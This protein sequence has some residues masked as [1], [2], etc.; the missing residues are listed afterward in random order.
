MTTEE[1]NKGYF[2][3]IR[4]R[5]RIERVDEDFYPEF[6]PYQ[7][8][9]KWEEDIVNFVER[10]ETLYDF[11]RN[12]L[13]EDLKRWKENMIMEVA[14]ENFTLIPDK[15]EKI[16]K[17]DIYIGQRF[18]F[19]EDREEYEV[20]SIREDR[21]PK[22]YLQGTIYDTEK[23][24]YKSDLNRLIRE[25][26]VK[27]LN[28]LK[29]EKKMEAPQ[30]TKKDFQTQWNTYEFDTTQPLTTKDVY[31]YLGKGGNAEFISQKMSELAGKEIII[32]QFIKND[33]LWNE[34]VKPFR[35]LPQEVQ[36]KLK[37]ELI[38]SLKNEVVKEQTQNSEK[39]NKDKMQEMSDYYR[40]QYE[41][42]LNKPLNK[43]DIIAFY[44]QYGKGAQEKLI[45]LASK[46]LGEQ[47]T[48]ETRKGNEFEEKIINPLKNKGFFAG[49][50]LKNELIESI[51]QQKANRQKS[52][53][54]NDNNLVIFDQKENE[55]LYMKRNEGG[56]SVTGVSVVT[57]NKTKLNLS[58]EE[59]NALKAENKN[60]W[61]MG[62]VNT[63][64]VGDELILGFTK[65]KEPFEVV[66]IEE[67]ENPLLNTLYLKTS[68]MKEAQ[69]MTQF[70]IDL[71]IAQNKAKQV[72]PEMKEKGITIH[73]DYNKFN[74]EHLKK[75]DPNTGLT[76]RNLYAIVNIEMS[77]NMDKVRREMLE[78]YTG[79][80]FDDLKKMKKNQMIEKVYEIKKEG[81]GKENELKSN[82]QKLY[83]SSEAER[84]YT[85]G[86]AYEKYLEG[87]SIPD[88]SLWELQ[89][90]DMLLL[91]AKDLEKLL[92]NT[93]LEQ[94]RKANEILNLFD[95]EDKDNLL[96]S[97]E[98]HL[99]EQEIAAKQYLLN[100]IN[101]SEN[102]AEI[103]ESIEHNL[104]YENTIK[105][106]L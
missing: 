23:Q 87:L 44:F 90:I 54:Q 14:Q 40:N 8:L 39:T 27:E 76:D 33:K 72:T 6:N 30:E 46:A 38:N 63:F 98:F 57:E 61:L 24:I 100:T 20:F 1:I 79:I 16:D 28:N 53:M 52:T 2:E 102:R 89:H 5:I 106:K 45:E 101:H 15:D 34:I 62:A 37:N 21:D 97:K 50:N 94:D 18:F 55:L 32:P 84:N 29:K 42:I 9:E 69:P 19:E 99:G 65:E 58:N 95:K 88:N 48:I 13:D 35:E 43:H 47:V 71:Y 93:P 81:N 12:R 77:E 86:A 64:K 60:N 80:P 92:E 49:K 66:K 59:W 75:I 73:K 78:K 17:G 26:K 10:A 96:Y 83:I 3:L 105:R 31:A 70:D 7:A 82:I 4:E 25:N 22:I 91:Q 103:K 41:I 11:I 36:T 104:Q 85:A 67:N 68:N 74:L 51:T 56:V